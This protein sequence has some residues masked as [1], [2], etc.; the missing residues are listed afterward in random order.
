LSS[1]QAATKNITTRSFAYSG[2][3]NQLTD[4]SDDGDE[5]RNQ[6]HKHFCF[7]SGKER[8]M[9]FFFVLGVEWMKA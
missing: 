4:F 3:K 7:H 6:I 5:I 2:G 8:R 1:L 9:P